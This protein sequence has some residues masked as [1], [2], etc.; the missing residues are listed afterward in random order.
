[1]ELDPAEEELELDPEAEVIEFMFWP[2]LTILLE[3][4]ADGAV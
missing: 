3:A 1:V 4:E 2:G